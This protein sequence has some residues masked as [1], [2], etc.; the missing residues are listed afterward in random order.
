MRDQWWE[1]TCGERSVGVR[2]TLE[3]GLDLVGVVSRTLVG[4]DVSNLIGRLS[5]DIGNG[6]TPPSWPDAAAPAAADDDAAAD[7]V[8]AVKGGLGHSAPS[9]PDRS[10]S[11]E[12]SLRFSTLKITT[13]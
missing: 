9:A 1:E 4:V 11:G 2:R 5:G 8:G 13:F 3:A 6:W 10:D 12:S 7:D